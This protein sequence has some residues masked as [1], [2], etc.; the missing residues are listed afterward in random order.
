MIYN[1]AQSG[2]DSIWEFHSSFE[3]TCHSDTVNSFWLLLL[4]NHCS[5]LHTNEY[6]ELRL[7]RE[8]S[9]SNRESYA[10]LYI[11]Y[12]PK[13]YKYVFTLTRQAKEDTEDIIQEIFLKIWEKRETLAAI[14]SFENYLF[15]TA[16]NILIN[17]HSHRLVKDRA[18]RQRAY[19]Q[20][21]AHTGPEQDILYI[22]YHKTAREAIG[23]MPPKRQQIFHLS[24]QQD[25][26]L[27]EIA[28][29]TGLSKAGVKKQLYTAIRFI[30]EYL[31]KHAELI[32]LLIIFH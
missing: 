27:D 28:A 12:T 10:A 20:P 3:N 23:L 19:L 30:K 24:T 25:R 8:A 2:F 1:S 11:Y 32:P 15:R 5:L 14:S 7:L 4:L 31:K 29:I 17:R 22:S 9:E 26:S 18:L 6:N 16:R 13:L 21:N